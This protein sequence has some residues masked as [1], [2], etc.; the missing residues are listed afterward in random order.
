MIKSW[1]FVIIWHLKEPSWLMKE[2]CLHTSPRQPIQT[3]NAFNLKY[4]YP[5]S[6]KVK[7][8]TD[9]CKQSSFT[10]GWAGVGMYYSWNFFVFLGLCPFR[11]N[12][13]ASETVYENMSWYWEWIVTE[14]V[15]FI[16]DYSIGLSS[17]ISMV[18]VV[19]VTWIYY[20]SIII[21]TGAEFTKA[22]ANEMG[23][24]IFPDEYAVAVWWL[25]QLRCKR[26][27]SW[28]WHRAIF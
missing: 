28:F 3:W 22:W 4:P 12:E 26:L 8:H 11:T 27:Y 2:L 13:K 9:I 18:L 6:Q 24:K 23:S 16:L 15:I 7:C 21:Y 14:E 25:Q 10:F 20:S 19:F 17:C 5:H 1:F